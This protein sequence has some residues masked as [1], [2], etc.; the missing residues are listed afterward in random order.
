M[1]ENYENIGAIKMKKVYFFILIVFIIIIGNA[2][3]WNSGYTAEPPP[4]V[5]TST[6]THED[7]EVEMVRNAVL[8]KLLTLQDVN[9]SQLI[10]GF[11]LE[12]IEIT[13]D[14]SFATGWITRIDPETGEVM[15]SE[16]GIFLAENIEEDWK[17]YLPS[18]QE[19]IEAL[20]NAPQELISIDDKNRLLGMDVSF[21]NITGVM[22]D[23]GYLLPWAKDQAVNLSRSVS[24]DVD[25]P[26]GNAHYSFDF[27]IP[28]TM[29][30]LYASKAGTVWSFKDTVP[31]NDHSDVN[32]IVLRNADNPNLY[33]LYLH[34]AQNSIPPSLKSIGAHVIQGQLVGVA[35]NTGASTGHHL[36]FQVQTQPY[37][38]ADNP[39]WG[40]SVDI[41]FN[42]VGIYGGRPRRTYEYDEEICG[43]YCVDGLLTYISA[44]TLKGDLTP[45]VG[46]FTGISMGQIV[47]TRTINMSGWASDA[48]SGLY[49]GQLRALYKG[50]WH[51]LGAPFGS[52]FTYNW[53]LCSIDN[54]VPDGVVSVGLRLYDWDGNWAEYAGLK[55]FIKDFDCP[56][57]DPPCTPTADQIT[58]FEDTDHAGGCV[59]FNMGNYPD[60]QALGA[61]GENDAASILVGSN[62][63]ATLY[64]EANYHGH[65]ET[66]L[67]GDNNFSDNLIGLDTLSSLK[68]GS[69][70][71]NSGAPV[72][73]G[74][75]SGSSHYQPALIPLSW[76]NGNNS[77]EYQVRYTL[78][79]GS[80]VS[81]PWQKHPFHFLGSL[82]VGNYTWQVRARNGSDI[83]GSWSQLATFEVTPAMPL[84]PAITAPYTDDM[85]SSE[86]DWESSGLW[87]LTNDL[88]MS[89]SGTHSWWYQ[90]G[91]GDY[92]NGL[93]NYGTLTSPPINIPSANYFLRFWYRYETET[94]GLLWDQRWVQISVDGGSFIN[95]DQLQD[96]PQIFE[97]SSWLQSK[98]IDLS[99]YAGH[100]IQI[101]F[102][103]A[104]LDASLNA[105]QGWGIDDFSITTTEPSTC[106]DN[107][108]DDTPQD[109]NVLSYSET[110]KIPGEICPG[111][112]YDYYRFNGLTGDRI[113]IDIDAQT[114]G[115]PLDSYLVLLDSDGESVLA[116]HDDEVYAERLDPLLSYSLPHNGDYYIKV[117]AWKHPATGGNVYDYTI[118]L[119]K[120]SNPPIVNFLI[121]ES[122]KYIPV[123][124]FDVT[125]QIFDV[126]DGIGH[127]DFY[128]HNYDWVIPTWEH[129]GTDWEGS[130]GWSI[131]FDPSGLLE[132]NG[133][134]FYLNAFDKAA[135]LTS[136]GVWNIGVDLTPP[137]TDLQPLAPVQE[138]S[139]ILLTWTGSD[140]ASGLAYANLQ[141]TIGGEM[142][143]TYADKLYSR[144]HW[145]VGSP[146]TDY[147]F[148]VRG[149]DRAG[150][151][152]N[153]PPSPQ[154][155]SS[156][157]AVNI[158]CSTPDL[159]EVGEGDNSAALAKT[160]NP[161]GGAQVHNFCNLQT[162]DRLNDE[163]WVKFPAQKD[164]RYFI[165]ALPLLGNVGTVLELY[166]GD[167]ATLLD[168][169]ESSSFG[170]LAII[171][172]ISD[173]D[174]DVYLR[175]RHM[176]GR[177]IGNSVA[178]MLEIDQGYSLYF[179]LLNR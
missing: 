84:S 91:D 39:Y 83:A 165:R 137:S 76:E 63:Q 101:R 44:N 77:V 95:V 58:V 140:S 118:R 163:D 94:K 145:F 141:Y 103:F 146:G 166:T 159:Y 1:F 105:Y 56:P 162:P 122:N 143:Q 81:L 75:P 102:L 125:A 41:T 51:N 175:V 176:D 13:A 111:G 129:L 27:Y 172:W 53:D 38:P 45:P 127:V 24:H 10:G 149:V 20:R 5:P 85:E 151:I 18:E 139:A 123:E 46:D 174:D 169:G 92:D 54:P 3:N 80:T 6:A 98:A 130:D 49:S 9:V 40:V 36:H 35:D 31:N 55:H 90:G 128:W 152:E 12:N 158:L 124:P 73:L 87:V 93:P 33:Q 69:R 14:D 120:D 170:R 23:G 71:A 22:A 133:G 32:F 30:N 116:E 136:A 21:G 160:I 114:I 70:T 78:E 42:E 11:E 88:E 72:I 164:V 138:S 121:P 15:P 4:P 65:G 126:V 8:S 156:I 60:G 74:P 100:T 64:S 179:P 19:W 171:D 167:G 34:L 110:L 52:T 161:D 154:A 82:D 66:F 144:Q 104:S 47:D 43:G 132:R 155:N 99:A 107:R 168:T 148:R 37:W 25:I 62:V 131:N 96:D 115:S 109:A 178:Y 153:Y 50:A 147:G 134:A 150:N 79:G 48:D 86:E 108:Q 173:R 2:I 157:P 26:S 29:F 16:P 119:Y 113:V 142:W 61:I 68:V 67:S 117:R 59:V 97:T 28:Q 106:D 7:Q 17:I 135:N 177:V 112:D 57:I 89:R